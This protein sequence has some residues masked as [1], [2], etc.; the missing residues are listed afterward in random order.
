MSKASER[1]QDDLYQAMNDL[2]PTMPEVGPESLRKLAIAKPPFIWRKGDGH[3]M[4]SVSEVEIGEHAN[5]WAADR[6][7]IAYLLWAAEFSGINLDAA[8]IWV[9]APAVLRG[10]EP[11][12]E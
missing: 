9:E 4:V 11:G 1:R 6:K 7:R 12:A 2:R 10:E 5:T 3:C 8:S